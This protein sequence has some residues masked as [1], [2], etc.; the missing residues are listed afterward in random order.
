MIDPKDLIGGTP[1]FY[2]QFEYN[3]R[4]YRLGEI[5]ITVQGPEGDI[6]YTDGLLDFDYTEAMGSEGDIEENTVLCKLALPNTDVLDLHNRGLGMDNVNAEFGYYIVRVGRIVQTY[7]DR[8]VLY[9]GQFEAPQFGDPNEPNNFVAV[10]IEAHPQT[11]NQLLLNVG[12]IDERFPDRDIDTADGKPYPIVFGT[13]GDLTSN[14]ITREIYATPAYCIKK[15][16]SHNAQF[17]ICGHDI[18]TSVPN[19][20]KIID[21]LGQ[22][23][24][25]TPV[26]SVD[27]Y[28]NVYHYIT[29]LPSDNVAMPGYSGSGSSQSWWV[30][31]DRPA[32]PNRFGTDPSSVTGEPLTRAGDVLLF[33]MLR[34]GQTVDVGAWANITA[35][36]N[37][38]KLA[39]YIND[40]TMYAWEWLQGNILPLLPVSIRM[41]PNG[42]R[43][44]VD[45]LTIIKQLQPVARWR[46]DDNS[47]ITQN[48]P[49]TQLTESVD[50]INDYTVEYGYNGFGDDY[51]GISRC[52][53][54]RQTNNELKTNAAV[55][56][57][58]RYGVK[59][60][61][62]Q[63]NYV[64]DSATA[65]MI[66]A[67]Y[68]QAN[69]LPR[70]ELSVHANVQYGYIQIGDIIEL[71]APRLALRSQNVIVS[72]KRWA[73]T[74]WAFDLQYILGQS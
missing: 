54:I 24:T 35:I 52:R 12:V 23:T 25:K 3:S 6:L 32:L 62:T 64:Y 34:T 61:A 16:D 73:G 74:V 17:M 21:D 58:N 37:T 15:Y 18:V 56:S 8:V 70:F 68:V 44:V 20:V 72:G 9:R 36:L 63:T 27:Q 10:S 1:V 49:I 14:G 46:V 41:G 26:R 59:Q 67:T 43:P 42:L 69:A 55:A 40:P 50:I 11:P 38:Y 66:A 7:D 48:G 33:G 2:V 53:A 47:E 19:T 71:T 31:W 5:A 39:G 65:D 60:G 29:I 51:A 28:G 57:T 13:P 22:T 4:Q 30:H 45:L